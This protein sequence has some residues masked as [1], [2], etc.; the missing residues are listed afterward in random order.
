MP[1]FKPLLVSCSL[2][3]GTVAFTMG[4]TQTAT[5]NTEKSAIFAGGCFWCMEEAF[6]KIDGVSEVV[7]GYS[8]GHDPEPDYRSVS[9]GS[10]GH[11]EVV[12]VKYDPATVSY[13]Q[14]VDIFW[15]NI[16]PTVENQ[17]F[18][19]KGSQ[20]RSGIYYLNDEQKEVAIKSLQDLKSS[21][22]FETIYTEIEPAGKFFMAEAY[23]QDYYKK[24]PF[25]YRYYK[26]SCGRT[27]RLEEVWGSNG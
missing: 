17:Q 15:K 6:E 19:D 12:E 3:L 13:A 1:N 22:R 9:A 18:C 20:Y 21:G 27:D 8:N 16:D 26:L 10:T 11:A 24:N 23:H 4:Y 5:A 14:L 7:S 2:V 25:R